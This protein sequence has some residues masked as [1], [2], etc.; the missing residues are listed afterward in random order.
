MSGTFI[1]NI[2]LQNIATVSTLHHLWKFDKTIIVIQSSCFPKELCPYLKFPN[3]NSNKTYPFPKNIFSSHLFF[4]ISR[5]NFVLP[6]IFKTSLS[7]YLLSL[8]PWQ[9]R[10]WRIHL[11]QHICGGFCCFFVCVFGFCVCS[12]WS[13]FGFGIFFVVLAF[14]CLFWV[15]DF[16]VKNFWISKNWFFSSSYQSLFSCFWACWFWGNASFLFQ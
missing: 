7:I 13:F 14:F 9:R 8:L 10:V 3:Q 1:F 2:C 11:W 12:C 6:N 16:F 5:T 4:F 15:W